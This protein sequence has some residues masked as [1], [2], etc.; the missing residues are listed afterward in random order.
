M[1]AL[2]MPSLAGDVGDGGP[3]AELAKQIPGDGEDPA[4]GF[5]GGVVGGDVHREAELLRLTI[6][7]YRQSSFVCQAR[8][9]V[10]ADL[11]TSR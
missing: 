4:A 1:L 3:R 8:A 11:A 5:L 9:R 6:Y 10:T 2:D 7:Y